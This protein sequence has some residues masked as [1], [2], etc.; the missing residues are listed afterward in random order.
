MYLIGVDIGGTKCAVTL[1]CTNG[2]GVDVL[3]K[4]Q[5]D[6]YREIDPYDALDMID[7]CVVQNLKDTDLSLSDIGAVGISCGGPLNSKRGVVLRPPNLIKWDEFYIVKLMEERFSVPTALCNDANACALAEWKF[8]AGRDCDNMIFLTCGTGMGAGLILDG[9]LYSGTSDLAGEV[10]HMRLSKEGPSGF[11]KCGSFEG[12]CGGNGIAQLGYTMALE[13]VQSGVSVGYFTAGMT[14]ANIS[15]R[16]IALAAQ[17][18]DVTAIEVYRK[19]GEYMG[20]ALSI[21][22]DILN[23][24]KIVIGSVYQRAGHLMA[25]SIRSVISQEAIEDSAAVCEVIPAALGDN[26]GDIA[27]LTIALEK[28][29]SITHRTVCDK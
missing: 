17:N 29:N 8:G 11:G 26:I 5:F 25:E 9:R 23:P 28:A 4:Q 19:S 22:I 15:A 1:G 20:M 27:A 6:S 21:L 18:G 12:W 2:D 14:A 10:G 3:A 7:E 16:T 24:Q 13:A